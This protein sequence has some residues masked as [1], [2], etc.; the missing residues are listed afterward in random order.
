MLHFMT[1]KEMDLSRT[2]RTKKELNESLEV[3][4]LLT[5]WKGV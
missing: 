5:N 3:K 4:L 2:K 1:F